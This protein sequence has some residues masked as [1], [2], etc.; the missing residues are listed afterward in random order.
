MAD[1]RCATTTPLE[2]AR[3]FQNEPAEASSYIETADASVYPKVCYY[4]VTEGSRPIEHVPLVEESPKTDFY[5]RASSKMSAEVWLNPT[6]L[7]VPVILEQSSRLCSTSN[8]LEVFASILRRLADGAL[9]FGATQH[10]T[11]VFAA[12]EEVPECDFWPPHYPKVM[13][14]DEAHRVPNLRCWHAQEQV[15]GWDGFTSG[16]QD[17]S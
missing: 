17:G 10:I 7:T 9:R 16:S 8:K 11:A 14:G 4:P 3:T 12:S 13:R 2:S 1:P 5:L 6:G 15:L